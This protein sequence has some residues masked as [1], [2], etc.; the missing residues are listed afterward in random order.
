MAHKFN[1]ADPLG[2]A[3]KL[4]DPLHLF[5]KSNRNKEVVNAEFR[6][7]PPEQGPV[8]ASGLSGAVIGNPI[9][10]EWAP[11]VIPLKNQA[12][13]ELIGK[14]YSV[15]Q[16]DKALHWGEEWLMGM[17]RRLAPNNSE[18]QKTVVVSGYKD[19]AGRS[20]K[21]LQGMEAVFAPRGAQS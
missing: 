15:D 18:L 4:P 21:W 11:E 17:A 9:P 16:V 7:L 10:I 20:E 5:T 3:G 8:S 14:G 19:I 1:F 2:I 13:A 12:R 6:E